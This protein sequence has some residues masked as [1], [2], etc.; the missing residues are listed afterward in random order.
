MGAC[1][2]TRNTQ[3]QPSSV[4]AMDLACL[5]F[6][7][8]LFPI[9]HAQTGDVLHHGPGGQ[10]ERG[11]GRVGLG[12]ALAGQAEGQIVA[13]LRI[14]QGQ[15][16]VDLA[17]GGGGGG[18]SSLVAGKPGD[19]GDGGTMSSETSVISIGTVFHG[20][21]GTLNGAK[22]GRNGLGGTTVS[23]PQQNEGVIGKPLAGGNGNGNG[24]GGGAGYYGGGGSGGAGTLSSNQPGGAGGGSSFMATRV[25]FSGLSSNVT[26]KLT[27]NNTSSSGG[28]IVITYLGKTLS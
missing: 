17:A 11:H 18:G 2:S 15:A 20:K 21:D 5:L 8:R 28:S 16:G 22:E 19:G 10:G 4:W 23:R 12:G 24:G 26:S 13:Q 6:I 7:C 3:P 14:G 9:S 1:P 27:N 25:T